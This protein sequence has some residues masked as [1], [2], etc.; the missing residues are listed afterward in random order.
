MHLLR[1]YHF[2]IAALSCYL[3]IQLQAQEILLP[4]K[5]NTA[6]MQREVVAGS[7]SIVENRDTLCMPFMDDFSAAQIFVDGA[8]TE[9]G[10]SIIQTSSSIYPSS[11]FWVDS[12]AFVNR[13]YPSLPPTYGVATLDGLNKYGQP[14]NETSTLGPAD[15]LTSKPIFV[16]GAITDSVY[17]SFYYQPGGFGEYPNLNDSLLLDFKAEDGTWSNVWFAVNTL[18]DDPQ[19]FKLVMIPVA[20]AYHYD[21]FQFRFRNWAGINGNNDHWHLDYVYLDDDRTYNDTLFRDVAI[22][23][24]PEPYLRRYRQ[25]P[26]NQFKDHQAEEISATHGVFMYNNFNTIVNTSHAYSVVEKYSGTEVM[27]LSAPVSVNLDPFTIAFDSYPNFEIPEA[28]P[29]YNDDSLSITFKYQLEPSGD[30]NHRND[31]LL[32][33]QSFYNYFAYDDGSAELAYQLIGLG[34]KLAMRFYANEPDTIKEIYIH[35]AYLDGSNS[36]KFFSLLLWDNID[37]TGATADENIIYQ[38]DFLTPKYIDSING[39][40][41]YKLVDFLG[42]PAPVVVDGY[43]YVGWLQ[44]QE[45]SL[46]IGFDVNSDAKE[47]VFY[48]VGGTWQQSALS[49][50]IMLR[51]QLGGNYSMYAPVENESPGTSSLMVYPNPATD[52]LNIYTAAEELQSVEIFDVDGRRVLA[53][54]FTSGTINIADLSAGIYILKILD[55]QKAMLAST[56]FVKQ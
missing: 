45:A 17:L 15:M 14:Y 28:T 30:I 25:M 42:N 26:W 41:V 2:L 56:T 13:T 48:N 47:N 27:P 40:Y 31:T 39:F 8:F 37:T 50:A 5:N 51:P 19:S 24:Q 32:H 36:N 7:R 18:G 55:A 9:C 6:L 11:I 10:D 20:D 44:S 35:W 1:K 46:D 49:G 29:G 53:S 33:D 3:P 22:I 34:S 38:N 43:F 12:N 16:G 23:Y 21:G 4:L 52:I 54:D